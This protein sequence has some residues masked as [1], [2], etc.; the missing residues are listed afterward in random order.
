MSLARDRYL[1]HFKQWPNWGDH[2]EW[3]EWRE[4]SQRL[5]LEQ[6]TDSETVRELNELLESQRSRVDPEYSSII[7]RIKEDAANVGKPGFNEYG[8]PLHACHGYKHDAH[9][10]ALIKHRVEQAKQA[11]C[12]K[13]N[14]TEL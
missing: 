10:W 1:R 3:I 8:L 13:Q 7:N 9:Y 12:L 5:W 14:T 2:R 11:E 6:A 4:K